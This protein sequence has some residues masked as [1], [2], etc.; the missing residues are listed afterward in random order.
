MQR[1][2]LSLAVVIAVG[3]A[4]VASTGAF[5][6]DTETSTGNSFT[7]GAI[8]L[9]VDSTQHYDG[10]I[11]R[12]PIGQETQTGY[13]WQR[14]NAQVPSTRE[15]L[16]GTACSGTWLP[17]DLGAGIDKFFSFT[18]VKP[19]DSGE[20]TVSLH[21]DNNPAWAC[22]DIK[23]VHNDDN[24]ITGPEAVVDTSTST[25]TGFG[26]LAQNMQWV[27]WNDNGTSTHK[28]NNV[29]DADETVLSQGTGPLTNTSYTLADGGTGTPITPSGTSYL[30]VAW[31]IGSFGAVTPGQPLVCNGSS[32]GNAAQ[33]DSYSADVSF[34]VEQSRNNANF[35]CV[36]QQQ[37]PG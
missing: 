20:N 23:N 31:C 28:G 13:T 27:V 21:I 34:R 2:L 36:P 3:G 6:N 26:E 10:L 24:S 19:G 29:L 11:C 14:E 12:L 17:K 35:R 8:D 25:P 1:I 32:V 15:D 33:T 37:I 30:G 7:A 22:V 18:D 5:F 16:V 9:K 4:A